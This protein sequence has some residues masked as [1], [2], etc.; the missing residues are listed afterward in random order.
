MGSDSRTAGTTTP[1]VPELNK[2]IERYECGPVRLAG[3]GEALYE[4][5]QRRC[6][7]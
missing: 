3:T 6:R 7:T 1:G 2:L 4:R 5:H